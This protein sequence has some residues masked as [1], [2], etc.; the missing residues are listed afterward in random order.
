[1]FLAKRRYKSWDITISFQLSCTSS[2]R[3]KVFFSHLRLGL[4]SLV[5]WIFSHPKRGYGI[6]MQACRQNSPHLFCKVHSCLV[7]HQLNTRSLDL[8]GKSKVHRQKF[9]KFQKFPVTVLVDLCL[10]LIILKLIL[11]IFLTSKTMR[12]RG[13]KCCQVWLGFFSTSN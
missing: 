11:T 1:M 9:S 7:K 8:S 13:L 2:N 12:Y 3:E 5:Q 4:S 10:I 6:F